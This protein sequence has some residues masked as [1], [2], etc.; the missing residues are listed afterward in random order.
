MIVT[1]ESRSIFSMFQGTLPQLIAVIS[2][3]L[4]ALSDGMNYGWTAPV[5][6]ILLD[7]NS[8]IKTTLHECEWLEQ[9]PNFGAIFGLPLTIYLVDKIGRKKSLLFASFGSLLCWILIALADRMEYLYI[10]RFFCG[11][12][13]DM[14]FVSGPMYIAEVADQKIRGFL[15]SLIYLMMLFGIITIYSVTPYVPFVVPSIIAGVLLITELVLFPFMPESPYYLLYIGKREEAKRSL[16]KLRPNSNV[17]YELDEIEAA[18][19]RQKGEKGR[20]QDLVL[21]KS[22]RKALI[23]LAFLNGAQNFG[24][25]CVMIMNMHLILEEAGS[26]YIENSLAA[27][28]FAVIMLSAA[29]VSSFFMDKYGRRV[30]L[31]TSA[32][33]TGLCLLVLAIYFTLKNS[34]V[35]VLFVS[36]IPI[37]SVMAYAC[38]FKLGLGMVPIVLTAELFP[39]KMKAMGMTLADAMYVIF[40]MISIYLYQ[41]LSQSYGIHVPFYLFSA[42]CFFTA[43]FTVLFIPETKGKTLEEIQF[44]L[45]GEIH[46]KDIEDFDTKSVS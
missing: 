8:H 40:S 34:G 30:L 16:E 26:I 12:N 35:E 4:V 25:I 13:G 21:V 19:K 38:V 15:S 17:E 31:T 11:M 18:I 7:E 3:S 23:I 9:I 2:G 45:K 24:S 27:I 22:N 41:W 32:I 42:S 5:I 37:V 39:A 36:W 29:T 44:I 10:A 6:P 1:M 33:L 14:A 20:P 46:P 28:I 43:M